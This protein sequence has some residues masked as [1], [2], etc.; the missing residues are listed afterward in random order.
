MIV[1]ATASEETSWL[2]NFLADIP[3]WFMG[4]TDTSRPYPM[5]STVAIGKVKNS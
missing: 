1:L 5:Q 3:L 4:E 2:R